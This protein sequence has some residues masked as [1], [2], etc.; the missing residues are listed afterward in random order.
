MANNPLFNTPIFRVAFPS[1]FEPHKDSGKYEVVMLFPKESTDLTEMKQQAA[2]A[3]IRTFKT[4]EKI[5]ADARVNPFGDGDER[6]ENAAED[7]KAT[8]ESFRGMWYVNAKTKFPPSVF[9]RRREA[10]E[11]EEQFYAGCWAHARVCAFGYDQKSSGVAFGLD[12]LLFVRHDAPF[13]GGGNAAAGFES[14]LDADAD[15]GVNPNAGVSTAAA[16]AVAS[17]DPLASLMS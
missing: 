14:L 16:P 11:K 6:Y 4:K 3:L 13:K 9:N 1:V 2:D 5:P 7:K 15:E 12:S 8:Y 10:L 17:D